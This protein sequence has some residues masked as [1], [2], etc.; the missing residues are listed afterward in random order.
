MR[1]ETDISELS[2]SGVLLM[3]YKDE[4]WRL[5]VFILKLLNK[6]ERNHKFHNKEMLVIIR[7]LETWRYFWKG[8]KGQFE[9]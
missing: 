3:K 4:K 2:T 7:Y 5:V 6:V 9:I 1:V 8:A